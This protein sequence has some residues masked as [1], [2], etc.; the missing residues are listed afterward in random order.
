[1]KKLDVHGQ[2]RFEAKVNM[3]LFLLEAHENR[4]KYILISHGYGNLILRKVLYEIV[5]K[6]DYIDKIE[7]APYQLGGPG[8][9]IVTLRGKSYGKRI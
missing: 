2:N 7:D 1:M 8:C 9:S 4:E 5:D 3:E 6:L